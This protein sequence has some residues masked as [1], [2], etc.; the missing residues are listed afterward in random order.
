MISGVF[1]AWLTFPTLVA[2]AVGPTHDG[3]PFSHGHALISSMVRFNN[4]SEVRYSG[5]VNPIP[6][7]QV[8]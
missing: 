5:S 7:G 4:M 2:A 3:H 8:S 6:P 1:F